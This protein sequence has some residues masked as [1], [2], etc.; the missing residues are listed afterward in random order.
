MYNKY[1]SVE[2]APD[3][4]SGEWVSTGFCGSSVGFGGV[5]VADPVLTRS[6]TP[7]I[8]VPAGRTRMLYMVSGLRPDIVCLV[9]DVGTVAVVAG[10]PGAS[11]EISQSGRPGI[12]PGKPSSIDVDV[13][14]KTRISNTGQKKYNH[15]MI[16]TSEWMAFGRGLQYQHT[17]RP[18]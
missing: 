7:A 14:L 16:Q 9:S 2:R 12:A 15:N 5:C 4:P 8:P 11:V 10:S 18:V 3:S 1:Y 6:T 17:V 13:V